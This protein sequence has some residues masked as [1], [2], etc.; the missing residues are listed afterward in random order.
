MTASEE[1]GSAPG[2][3]GRAGQIL[4]DLKRR[5]PADSARPWSE[6][7]AEVAAMAE[8]VCRDRSGLSPDQAGAD[9]MGYA[10]IVLAA[11]RVLSARGIS[12]ETLLKELK[13]TMC[14]ELHGRIK[15]YLAERFG[16]RPGDEGRAMELIQANFIDIGRINFGRGWSYRREPTDDDRCWVVIE[17]CLFND[18]FRAV[19]E[20]DLIPLFCAVDTVWA[21]ELARPEYGVRFDRPSLLAHGD[22]GCRFRFSRA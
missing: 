12:R 11:Y 15:D 21:E 8:R 6:V 17:K 2:P 1:T 5:L 13:Q 18:F 16:V 10:A 9:K 22:S 14:A 4:A 19:G 3:I 20:P 7:E